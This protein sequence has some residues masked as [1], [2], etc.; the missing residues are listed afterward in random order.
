MVKEVLFVRNMHFGVKVVLEYVGRVE[1]LRCLYQSERELLVFGEALVDVFGFDEVR[2]GLE[3]KFSARDHVGV[4]CDDVG[5]F[6]ALERFVQVAC[7]GAVVVGAVEVMDSEFFGECAHF[8]TAV[9]IA[10]VNVDLALV[11]VFYVLAAD[12]GLAQ[13]LGRFVV[14][15]DKDVYVWEFVVCNFR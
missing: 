6:R 2:D 8:A 11:G 1:A 4:E 5:R 9:V 3:Q 7:F 10:E 12:D 14:R 15:R 13:E